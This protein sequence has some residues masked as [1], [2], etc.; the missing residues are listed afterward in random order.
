MAA[1]ANTPP[2]YVFELI[3][4]QAVRK[5]LSIEATAEDLAEIYA[6]ALEP[7]YNIT[8]LA[9]DIIRY[10]EN[11]L[12]FIASVEVSDVDLLLESYQYYVC[13]F[14]N[15]QTKR[16]KRPMFRSLLKGQELD[17]LRV[18]K[19]SKALMAYVYGMRANTSPLKPE[20][21]TPAAEE[22]FQ[23]IF[24]LIMPKETPPSA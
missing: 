18:Y 6:N 10:I 22:E 9:G 11:T 17:K 7:L 3:A 14:E 2:Q 16:N 1:A 13:N 24:E 20:D 23:P 5:F 12:K 19:A 15:L 8:D 21:W 4:V